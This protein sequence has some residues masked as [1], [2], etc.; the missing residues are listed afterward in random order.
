MSMSTGVFGIR[1][2]NDKWKEMKKIYD[3]CVKLK[4]DIPE[5]VWEFFNEETPEP[6]GVSINLEGVCAKEWSD[7]YRAGI[8][9]DVAKLPKGVKIIRFYNSW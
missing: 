7:D 8:E 1:P 2:P 5:F 4:Q 9:I 3:S 6:D